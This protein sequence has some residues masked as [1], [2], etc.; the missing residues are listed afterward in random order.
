MSLGAPSGL[1]RVRAHPDLE[2]VVD[3]QLSIVP[4]RHVPARGSIDAHNAELA[5]RMQEEGDVYVT[6]AVIDGQTV[7][8]P[9]ITN[10]RTT[11]ADIEALIET[12]LRTGRA[13]E[14]EK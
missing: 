7:L 14:G 4:F 8:R 1:D 13:L 2:L 3:P 11:D 12:V 9:C 6:S 10:F 5:R